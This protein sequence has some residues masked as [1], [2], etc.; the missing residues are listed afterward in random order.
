MTGHRISKKTLA[1]AE[2]IAQ[3]LE[4][5]RHSKPR[6]PKL[7]VDQVRQSEEYRRRLEMIQ[8]VREASRWIRPASLGVARVSMTPTAKRVYPDF[9]DWQLAI[10]LDS[11][12]RKN[13]A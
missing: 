4:A 2:K 11:L 12:D 7:D 13:S 5:R 10:A 9:E 3:D 6:E 1:R 8:A